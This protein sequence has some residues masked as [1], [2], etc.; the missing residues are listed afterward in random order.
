M[1]RQVNQT[2]SNQS[3]LLSKQDVLD[4]CGLSLLILIVVLDMLYD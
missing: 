1:T 4:G 2:N 3:F